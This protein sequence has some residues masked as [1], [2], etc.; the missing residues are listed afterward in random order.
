MRSYSIP[1]RYQEGFEKFV[2]LGQKRGAVIEVFSSSEIGQMP[3]ELAEVLQSKVGLTK[4]DSEA[5]VSS[6]S[7]MFSFYSRV[8]DPASE[9]SQK[10]VTA[11]NDFIVDSERDKSLVKEIET[12]LTKAN[13]YLV[14]IK[15][16]DLVYERERVIVGFRVLSDIRPVFE[17]DVG[18]PKSAIVLHTLEIQYQEDGKKKAEY[19]A[20]DLDDLGD[21]QRQMVRAIEKDR[22]LRKKLEST[23]FRIINLNT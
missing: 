23:S 2:S 14:A 4:D 7:S 21:F 13:N 1:T 8:D 17:K 20:L 15:A 9:F 18:E 3:D 19:F 10:F 5:I 22:V 11:L 12:M 16:I 6:V